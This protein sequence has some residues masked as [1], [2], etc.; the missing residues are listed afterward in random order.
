MML[1]RVDRQPCPKDEF[2]YGQWEYQFFYRENFEE[3][4][5]QLEAK[6]YNTVKCLFRSGSKETLNKRAQ[7]V[8]VRKY[9]GCLKTD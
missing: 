1:S 4:Q 5:K 7:T 6:S 8:F 9:N 2:P 3:V